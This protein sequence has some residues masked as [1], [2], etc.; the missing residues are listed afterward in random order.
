M[1]K[2]CDVCSKT[3]KYAIKQRHYATKIHLKNQAKTMKSVR[4]P[5]SNNERQKHG[6]DF[7]KYV[8]KK[9][10]L[11]K[12]SGYTSKYDAY[13]PDNVPVQIKYIKEKASIEMGD[14]FRNNHKHVEFILYIGF[15][16]WVSGSREHTNT[17]VLRVQPDIWNSL[18]A[19]PFYDDMKQ[20]LGKI[21]NDVSDDDKWLDFRK[22]YTC[23]WKR[24]G[25]LGSIR[26]KRDHKKQKRIQCALTP[27]TLRAVSRSSKIDFL[28]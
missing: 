10:S 3:F 19:C 4:T 5:E 13:T 11:V 7:E 27:R 26:F 9:H 24:A 12:S 15:W 22:K 18:F 23:L 8:I 25:S 14:L 16:R 6:F 28:S 17:I 21:S 1:S 20:E 2:F